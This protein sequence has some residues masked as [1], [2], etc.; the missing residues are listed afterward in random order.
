V[1]SV[2]G[3]RAESPNKTSGDARRP[4]GR[5]DRVTPLLTRKEAA[6]VLATTERHLRRL[7]HE[8]RIGFVKVGRFV[9]F[10]EADIADFVEENRTAAKDAASPP[11]SVAP[12]KYPYAKRSR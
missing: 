11:S 3:P 1:S 8:R 2:R 10:R 5:E 9:R 6:D 12:G 4:A 7:V